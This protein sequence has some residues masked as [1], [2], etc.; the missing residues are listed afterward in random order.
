MNR[1]TNRQAWERLPARRRAERHYEM[2]VYELGMLGQ[3]TADGYQSAMGVWAALADIYGFHCCAS[4]ACPDEP[5]AYDPDLGI[6]MNAFRAVPLGRGE[7]N[8]KRV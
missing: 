8:P 4:P 6:P 3:A 1:R 5:L 2:T 7:H